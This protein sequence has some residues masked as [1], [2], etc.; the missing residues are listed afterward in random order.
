L[1]VTECS[2]L[3]VAAPEIET[4]IISGLA[5]PSGDAIRSL[6]ALSGL[7][8]LWIEMPPISC[9]DLVTEAERKKSIDETIPAVASLGGLERLTILNARPPFGDLGKL[10]GLKVLRL[11]GLIDSAEFAPALLLQM[12]EL[13]SVYFSGY[14]YSDPLAGGKVLE[15]VSRHG[16]MD[17]VTFGEGVQLGTDDLVSFIDA[18]PHQFRRLSMETVTVVFTR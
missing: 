7:K 3:V 14:A 18:A 4:L 10:N 12:P 11:C 8:E 13:E 9:L 2:K 17:S 6:E 5:Y 15:I 1:S 16:S